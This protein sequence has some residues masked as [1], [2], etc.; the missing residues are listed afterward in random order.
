MLP[1][2]QMTWQKFKN[3]FQRENVG[4]FREEWIAVLAKNVPLY[5]RLPEALRLRLHEKI[6]QFIATIRFEG[7]GG[8]ELT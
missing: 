8:Q 7:C 6:G 2:A 4:V 3:F 5:T 1:T